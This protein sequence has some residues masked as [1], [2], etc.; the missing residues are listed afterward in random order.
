MGRSLTPK[1]R[2][3]VF[4]WAALFALS[5][6]TA[7]A[8]DYVVIKIRH[9][10]AGE[11]VNVV[12]AILSADGTVIS[13]E[14]NNTL[15]VMDSPGTLRKVE[16]LIAV[17]DIPSRNVRLHVTFFETQDRRMVDLSVRWRY[18][19]GGFMVGD[20][21]DGRG[22]EGLWIAGKVKGTEMSGTTLTNQDLLVINGESGRFVTG[23]NVPIADAVIT[24]FRKHG[25]MREEVVFREIST[26]FIFTP[27][28]LDEKIELDI[29][30]FL[31]YFID[32]KEGSV[33]FYEAAT[34]VSVPDGTT[35]VIA[36]NETE[37]GKLVGEVFSGF[38]GSE[39]TGKFYIA[40]TPRIED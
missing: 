22:A 33:V 12:G 14:R 13:D 3:A 23:A 18:K 17:L 16:E 29:V 31:S 39:R 25:I 2:R 30:P 40:V 38:T 28:I 34:T 7:Y 8:A 19:N 5:I 15:I 4:I 35:V 32:E 6:L 1:I 27:T 10:P 20:Y 24:R 9:R 21:I 37:S 11:L 36:E 26:G